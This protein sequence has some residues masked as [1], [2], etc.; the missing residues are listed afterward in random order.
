V[1]PKTKRKARRPSPK[2]AAHAAALLPLLKQQVPD[3]TCE[4]VHE[5]AWQLLVAT[6]LSAQ[7][8]DRGVN[9]VTPVLFAKYPTPAALAKAKPADV[10][11]I[12]HSTGFFRAKTKSI[13]ATARMLVERHGGEVPRTMEEM[14]QLKGVARKT[15]NV[16]LGTA[17]R[18]PTGITVDVHATRTSQRL[19]LTREKD[20]PKIEA[21]LMALYPQDEWIDLGH[22]LVLLG[23][24]T[25][26]ARGPK[27]DLCACA[28][29]CPSSHGREVTADR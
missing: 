14:L 27:C 2:L 29:A 22:R 16:V 17:Y 20:P 5:N 26:L 15:A 12:I 3:A 21:A 24:Y 11:K 10:E 4:L 9:K 8:T 1:K 18:I 6:I 19:G 28:A 13:Q 7:S 25:C 23:R